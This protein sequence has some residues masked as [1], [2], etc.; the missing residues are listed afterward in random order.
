MCRYEA[1]R[2]LKVLD[3]QIA[4]TSNDI[5]RGYREIEVIPSRYVCRPARRPRGPL[6]GAAPEPPPQECDW[7][8]PVTRTERINVEAERAKL[9]S[10]EQQRDRMIPQVNAALAAC[11]KD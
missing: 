3:R 6:D 10:L 11:P 7:T 1:T 8:E 5:A 4:E 2:D 9:K